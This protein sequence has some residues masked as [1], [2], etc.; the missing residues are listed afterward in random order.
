MSPTLLDIRNEQKAKLQKLAD[1]RRNNPFRKDVGITTK[2][3]TSDG[4]VL[5]ERGESVGVARGGTAG[6]VGSSVDKIAPME[7]TS[8]GK[9]A[10]A[11]RTSV[12][13]TTPEKLGFTSTNPSP[14]DKK[15]F[16]QDW[17]KNNPD[18]PVPGADRPTNEVRVVTG[19]FGTAV[20]GGPS[21]KD[22]LVSQGKLPRDFEL[23]PEQRTGQA[24]LPK[25]YTAMKQELLTNAANVARNEGT[26]SDSGT[27]AVMRGVGPQGV[28]AIDTETAK[29]VAD[30]RAVQASKAS[31]ATLRSI[32]SPAQMDE[33]DKTIVEANKT[34]GAVYPK[35]DGTFGIRETADPFL[36]AP[37][38]I[39]AQLAKSP[40][41]RDA[42]DRAVGKVWKGRQAV[43]KKG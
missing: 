40:Q 13:T 41:G 6:A 3:E 24:P 39:K 33:L 19:R 2:I 11:N 4:R 9:K 38:Y 21:I 42:F 20:G 43:K 1:D 8:D 18:T 37:A 7:L 5:A 23:T 15:K 25:E 32:Y 30:Q 35:G 17:K 31:D 27:R 16:E 26:V 22:Q 10:I 28:A 29:A 36:E 12:A 34:R 14:E